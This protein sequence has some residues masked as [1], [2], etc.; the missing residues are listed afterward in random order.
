MERPLVAFTACYAAGILLGGFFEVRAAAAL[1][2][3]GAAFLAAL[4]GRILGRPGRGFLYPVLFVLLGLALGRL[5][6]EGSRTPLEELAG[7][8]VV[9]T[10]L[11]AA[12]PDVRPDKVFYLI[13]AEKVTFA[14]A[15][16]STYGKVRLCVR[17]PGRIHG[18]GE[19]LR[20]SGL[21]D[22]AEGPGNPGDFDYNKYLERQGIRLIMNVRGEGS[23]AALG[24]GGENPLLSLALYVK[25]KLSGAAA[26]GLS[27]A[28][29]AVLNGIVFGSQ[30][31]IEKSTREMYSETGIV[32]I[33][34]VSGLHVGILLGGLLGLFRLLR[35]SPGLTAPLA[36]PVLLFYSLMTGLVPPVLRSVL[37]ALLLLWAHHLGRDRDWPTTLALSAFA[38][39]LWRPLQ[40]YNPG[41]QLSFAATWGIL[42][43][44]PLLAG[45][46]ERLPGGVPSSL[47]RAIALG[48]GAPLGAQL[49]TLPLVAWYYSMV[50]PVSLPANLL[51][52]PV[53]SLI[54]LLG[55]LSSGLGLIWLPLAGVINASTGLLLDLFNVLTVFLH[56]LPGAVLFVPRPSLPAA[57]AWYAALVILAR[58][59]AG[60]RPIK[61][62]PAAGWTAAV[63]L[64]AA[65]ALI[66]W[67]PIPGPD[68]LT[69]QFIDV[70]QGDCVLVQ[71][72]G[73][74]LLIDAG[75][76]TGEFLT[77]SGAGDQVV[78]PYL[79]RIGVKRL[80]A[81]FI[82]H[83][84]EDHAGGA[85]AVLKSLPVG[86][87][88]VSPVKG[89]DD[90]GGGPDKGLSAVTETEPRGGSR[91]A[92]YSRVP[93]G[94][95]PRAYRVLLEEAKARG[96]N[97]QL[98]KAGDF[99][100]LD[101][102][103][104]I[105]VLS[106]DWDQ[107]EIENLNDASLVLK[108]TCGRRKFLLTGD[109]G[110][111]EQKEL[112]G[113]GA[114]LSA[115]VLKV[116]HHGSGALLPEFVKRVGATDAVISVGA[117]NTFGHPAQS[118]L[119]MLD[120][121]GA[122]IYR[123]DR[124]GAVIFRTD[125]EGLEVKTARNNKE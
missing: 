84:H 54:M 75:G 17:E 106:P 67:F 74:N 89:G 113:S 21:L 119:D 38:I 101:Q 66:A 71:K 32:H 24:K 110:P 82:T 121:A 69:L 3:A 36:T 104:E 90:G 73:R 4:A 86:M 53:V 23:I 1:V 47:K 99:M 52:V 14:G 77:G 9:L 112:L 122:Q 115:G 93:A 15:E 123:T 79:R 43:L 26:I 62:R 6:L 92:A 41:F 50:S 124:D 29:E 78:L 85:H 46:F 57:A 87:V 103:T 35:F 42:Y 109:A 65:A 118:T 100:E 2:L 114:D 81:L 30:G 105:E 19:S 39:L 7:H 40:I 11:V 88:V 34:S 68:K 98:A 56:R 59:I 95:V 91:G 94:E 37:M 18:Y 64:A 97:I 22:R 72:G 125:G 107:P 49:A 61:N 63:A 28:Q 16:K 5:A 83:P 45:I 48:A 70:G 108:L 102:I 31:M 96:V 27:P 20:V 10:G 120:E 76:R 116:P 111:D 117:H 58:L 60:W 51:A 25:D 33:L 13:E 55:L 44:A 12:E 8:R 80:D